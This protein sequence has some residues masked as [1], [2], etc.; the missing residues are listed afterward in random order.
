MQFCDPV[1]ATKHQDITLL[2]EAGRL[3]KERK[4]ERERE[5]ERC[6]VMGVTDA[7]GKTVT[8]KVAK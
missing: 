2:S 5:R 7:I 6:A 3:K 8:T 4:R 1:L